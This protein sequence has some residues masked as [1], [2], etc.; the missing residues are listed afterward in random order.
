MNY[1]KIRT[2]FILDNCKIDLIIYI[3]CLFALMFYKKYY[4]FLN[5]YESL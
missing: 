1:T 5:K 2:K 3:Q 4:S